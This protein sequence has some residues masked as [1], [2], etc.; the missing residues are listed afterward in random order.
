MPDDKVSNLFE[1]RDDVFVSFFPS[2]FEKLLKKKTI[3]KPAA[4][5]KK[6]QAVVPAVSASSKADSSADKSPGVFTERIAESFK[7]RQF[8]RVLEFCQVTR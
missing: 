6:V 5:E 7:S 8:R 4:S 1:A 3:A 2:A